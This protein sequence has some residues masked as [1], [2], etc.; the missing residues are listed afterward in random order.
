M[1]S[2]SEILAFATLKSQ[3]DKLEAQIKA[4]RE[5]LIN[6]VISKEETE[7]GEYALKHTAF[8]K[9]STKYKS[10]LEGLTPELTPEQTEILSSL[11]SQNSST[12]QEHRLEAVVATEEVIVVKKTKK[13][14]VVAA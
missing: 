5:A 12:K 7:A 6:R 2:Q 1:I 3:A 14:K 11:L 4:T 10:V 9:T 8:D 13:L